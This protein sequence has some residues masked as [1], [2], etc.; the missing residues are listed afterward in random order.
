MERRASSAYAPMALADLVAATRGWLH[1]EINEAFEIEEARWLI[2]GASKVQMAFTLKHHGRTLPL[3]L[4]MQP[5]ESIVETSRQ[6]EFEVMR[7]FGGIVPVPPVYWVDSDGEYLPYP[8]LISGFVPG[9]TKPAEATSQAT[10]MG[11]RIGSRWR[12]ALG[13]QFVDSL[14]RIHATPLF[15]LQLSSFE[16]PPPGVTSAELALNHWERVWEEDSD[17]EEPLLRLAAAWLRANLPACPQPV[18]VHGDFRTGNFLFTE[19]DAR[20]TAILDWE[21]AR[22]GDHHHDLAWVTH[23]AYGCLGDDGITPLIGGFMP[24]SEFFSRYEELSGLTIDPKRLYFYRVMAGF[25]QGVISLATSYRIARYGK[26]HQ[27]ALLAWIVGIGP[28]LLDQL[29]ALLEQGG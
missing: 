13:A 15:N 21:M 7:A 18:L 20:I 10:G 28:L 24:E 5:A 9:V 11:T 6:R 2:G 8:A 19:S 1:Q 22:I 17:E 27:D 25:I 12:T 29:R 16:S 23:P 4:R 3:V 14:A 26:T